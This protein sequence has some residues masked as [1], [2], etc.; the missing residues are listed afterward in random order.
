MVCTDI[1]LD[2]SPSKISLG[3]ECGLRQA[4]V[5]RAGQVQTGRLVAGTSPPNSR[6]D[7]QSGS[8]KINK[9]RRMTFPRRDTNRAEAATII[10]LIIRVS[11]SCLTNMTPS[12]TGMTQSLAASWE[13][14]PGNCLSNS[15]SS[16]P[17]D[18]PPPIQ[19]S[20]TH[21]NY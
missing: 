4:R 9:D 7:K 20:L 2:W 6:P 10:E 21:S 12:H 8:I 13:T 17:A 18:I 1:A 14:K 3:S 15:A 16:G 5:G 11:I 19:S